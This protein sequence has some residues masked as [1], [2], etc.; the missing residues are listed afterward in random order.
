MKINASFGFMIIGVPKEIKEHEYRVA[1]VPAGVR[2][3]VQAGHK[4]YIESEAG[5]GS[6]IPDTAFQ[7]A[8]ATILSSKEEIFSQADLIIKVKE[9]LPE[10]YP[11]LKKSQIIYAFLH[12]AASRELT[13]A[14]LEREVIAIA[15]ETVQLDDGFLPLLTPMSEIAGRLSVQEGAR[16]LEKEEGG[17]G[18]LLGGVPGVEPGK[19]LIIGGGVVG[20][21]AA[22][23]AIGHGADTTLL[24]LNLERMAYLDDLF[25][26]RI[27][28]LMSNHDNLVSHLGE[29]DLI[30]GGVLIPG[31]KAPKLI[32]RD[33]LSFIRK[34]SVFVD[35]SIDQGGCAETS[36]PTSFKDPTY[37]CEG[38][39][40]YCVTNMP[41]AVARTSTYALT[42]VTLPYALQIANKGVKKGLAENPALARGLNIMDGKVTYR[43]IAQDLGYKYHSLSSVLS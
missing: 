8:G 30:I 33:M 25:G 29:A 16:Y 13:E 6:G 39:I 28:T 14:L 37:T 19:V 18:V 27:K 35:V 40:H 7:K 5:E 9:P 36:R 12:L 22:K 32:T 10:E 21:N 34:G 24:E 38:V 15:Y 42:N 31:A 26:N 23:I 3:L 41:S 1:I 2:A 4:V 20:T 17:R 43:S 11:L